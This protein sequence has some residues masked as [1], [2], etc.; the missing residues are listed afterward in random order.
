MTEDN[1]E[2]SVLGRD[3]GFKV[4]VSMHL[5]HHNLTAPTLP[6]PFNSYVSCLT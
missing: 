2:V 3:G 4:C 6:A 5:E 1:V